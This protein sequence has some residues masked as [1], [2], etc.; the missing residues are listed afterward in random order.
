LP[1]PNRD[2]SVVD[3]G[4]GLLY[5]APLGTAEPTDITDAQWGTAWIELGY[6]DAGSTFA[7]APTMDDVHVAELT[8]PVIT[9]VSTVKITL[10]CAL[11]QKTA[12]NLGVAMGGGTIVTNG[13]PITLVTFEP[14]QAGTERAVMLG[15][16]SQALDEAWLW[17]NAKPEGSLS[18]QHTSGS[19]KATVPVTWNIQ[20]PLNA[21]VAPWKWFGSA[22][23]QG[24]ALAGIYPPAAMSDASRDIITREPRENGGKS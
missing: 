13:P 12:F 3:I 5:I 2:P 19:T 8:I 14:P 20:Q 4:P 7:I 6:T 24:P 16:R 18:V 11:A 23:R 10:V 1:T 17:R 9:S 22:K 15:W 21:T